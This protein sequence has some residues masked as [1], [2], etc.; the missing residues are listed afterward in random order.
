V[1]LVDF[2]HLVGCSG[3]VVGVGL[4]GVVMVVAGVVDELVGGDDSMTVGAVV[5]D[6]PAGW[7]QSE[8]CG[9]ELGDD[10]AVGGHGCALMVVRAASARA[11]WAR[12]R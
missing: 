4:L 11:R 8:W 7:E 9:G 1:L 12:R 6:V 3:T 2:P 5:F 10:G